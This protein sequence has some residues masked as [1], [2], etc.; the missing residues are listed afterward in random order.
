MEDIIRIIFKDLDV[1]DILSALLV[2]REWC[3]AAVPFYW[4]APFSFTSKRSG[5]TL[6][7]YKMFLEQGNI[8]SAQ[9]ETQKVLPLFD[10]PLFIKEL[11]YSNL[12]ML[13]EKIEVESILQMLTDR[14]VRLETFIIENVRVYNYNDVYRLWTKPCYASILNTLIHVEIHFPFI[15]NDFIKLLAENCMRLSHLDINIYNNCKFAEES[16]NSLEKLISAQCDWSWLNNCPNLTKFAI[17]N[18]SLQISRI[19]GTEHE[20]YHFK[21]SKNNRKSRVLTEHWHF[22]KD[23]GIYL[24]PKFYFH[25]RKSL[26]VPYGAPTVIQKIQQPMMYPI[27]SASLIELHIINE[28]SNIVEKF[29]KISRIPR[30]P[31]IPKNQRIPIIPKNQ[32][33]Q[34]IPGIPRNQR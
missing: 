11:N 32:R 34:R 20:P 33:I 1:C 27:W 26:T 18:P 14:D 30:I 2:N 16:I 9:G 25:P 17:T 21:P 13:V 8:T 3:R 29:Q 6:K 24:M 15:N 19:L 22:D 23:A 10:Y 31:R 28:P 7:T 4:K 12:L 5:A